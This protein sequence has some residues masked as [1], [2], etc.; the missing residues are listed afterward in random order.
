MKITVFGSGNI[1]ESSED[2]KM[3]EEFGRIAALKG[4]ELVNGGYYGIMLAT[5]RG[6]ALNGGKVTGIIWKDYNREP[7]KYLT[8]IIQTD[9][10]MTRLRALIDASNVYLIFPGGTGTLMELSTIWA[11]SERNILNKKLIITIGE[12]WREL[13]QLIGFYN[14]HSFESGLFIHNVPN[15]E[16]AVKLIE[17]YH[18]E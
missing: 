7:N 12:Q 17:D 8:N 2:F 13:I 1:D 18:L 14:E 9:N 16:E 10:Y 4:W 5:S 15:V 3:A 6:A 11:L